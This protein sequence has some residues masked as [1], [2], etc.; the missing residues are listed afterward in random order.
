[1]A[2]IVFPL[3]VNG[4]PVL[5]SADGTWTSRK[6]AHCL[7]VTEIPARAA[8]S[9]AK[10]SLRVCTTANASLASVILAAE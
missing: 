7:G 3:L 6:L 8:T 9:L 5:G 2:A 10:S 1:M 4:C